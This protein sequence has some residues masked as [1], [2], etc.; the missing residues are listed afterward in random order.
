MSAATRYGR[1]KEEGGQSMHL[2][3]NLSTSATPQSWTPKSKSAGPLT[4]PLIENAFAVRLP[5][6]M[7]DHI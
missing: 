5:I 4:L 3:S 2:T 6:Y 1:L 7:L